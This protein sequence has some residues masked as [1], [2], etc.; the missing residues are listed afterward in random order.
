MEALT[1]FNIDK[2]EVVYILYVDPISFFQYK[3]FE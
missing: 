1:T 2:I 3:G